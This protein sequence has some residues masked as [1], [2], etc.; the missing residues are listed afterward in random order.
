M[1]EDGYLPRWLAAVHPRYGTPARA[2]VLSTGIYSLLAVR[3]VVDLIAIYLWTRIATSL[4]TACSVWQMRRRQ[5]TAERRFRIPGGRL[6][7]AYV[8]VAPTLLCALGVAYSEPIAFKYSPWLL[9]AGPVAYL[10]L[11]WRARARR[12]AGPQD[13]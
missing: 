11:Q 4:L 8:V 10:L 1:A 2:I 7:L 5:P 12:A 3:A 9:L 13:R 6:G